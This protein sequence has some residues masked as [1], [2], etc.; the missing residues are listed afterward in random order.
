MTGAIHRTRL[1]VPFREECLTQDPLLSLR[2]SPAAV[3]RS[4]GNNM[5]LQPCSEGSP[6]STAAQGYETCQSIPLQH[7][8]GHLAVRANNKGTC[9]FVSLDGNAE[10]LFS[11]CPVLTWLHC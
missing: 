1:S 3:R 6:H 2:I 11:A 4:L 9:A 5:G 8:L 7:H 10:P